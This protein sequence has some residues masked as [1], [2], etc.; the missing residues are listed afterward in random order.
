MNPRSLSWTRIWLASP[1]SFKTA[2]Q[3]SRAGLAEDFLLPYT[4]DSN[5]IK[6][7]GQDNAERQHAV[8]KA[9]PTG[10]AEVLAEPSIVVPL[11]NQV[12]SKSAMQMFLVTGVDSKSGKARKL[13]IASENERGAHQSAKENGIYPTDIQILPGTVEDGI[14]TIEVLESMNSLSS[15]DP[16]SEKQDCGFE[17]EPETETPCPEC[18][19][20]I[21]S[22]ARKCP[23]CRSAVNENLELRNIFLIVFVIAVLLMGVGAY[24]SNQADQNLKRSRKMEID[25][26]AR[27]LQRTLDML[28][29]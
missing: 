19:K 17:S 16:P 21:S 1:K 11:I 27:E 24:L 22:I 6:I 13:K 3:V 15:V 8:Q 23:Y 28:K 18:R 9:R 2:F 20:L 12:K 5:L 26:S 29:N 4:G 25:N 14:K 10:V 7:L